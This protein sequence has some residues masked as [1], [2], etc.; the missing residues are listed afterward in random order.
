[1]TVARP[2]IVAGLPE[3][4][5]SRPYVLQTASG[6]TIPVVKE[7]LVELTIGRRTLRIWVF[8]ADI[9]EEFILGLDNQ[10]AYHATVDVG[11]HGLLPARMRCQ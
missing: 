8:F 6:K 7:A 11:R 3:R 2:D 4:K 9:T 10:R 1:V 5:L